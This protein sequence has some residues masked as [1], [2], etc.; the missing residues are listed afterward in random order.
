MKRFIAV[1]GTLLLI[2]GFIRAAVLVHWDLTGFGI[3]GAGAA[4]VL[5]A[6][7]W[8]WNDVLEWLRD[9]RGV[10]AVTTGISVAV[11]VAVLVML[12][13]AV[14]YRPWSVDLTASG[15]NQV[16]EQTKQLLKRVSQPVSLR[17]FGR[18]SDPR[19]EQLLRNFERE[20]SRV[21]VEIV[22][23][24]RER[25]QATRYGIIKLGTVV[26]ISGDKFRKIEDVN[27]QAIATALLQVTSNETR[28]VCFASGHGERKVDDKGPTGLSSLSATLQASNYQVDTVSLLEGDVPAK[29]NALVIAAPQDAYSQPELDR[30]TAYTD[31]QGP[32]A[33]LLEP[34]PAPSFA[35]WLKPRG[36]VP[37]GGVIVDTS[38]AGQTV[39]GGPR[40]PLA[41]RYLDHPVTRGFDIATL[42]DGARPLQVL[43]HPEYGGHPTGLAQTSARSFTTT[44]TD[45]V[46]AF[47]RAKDTAGPLTLAAAVARQVGKREDE[48]A[49]LVVFGDADFISNAFVRRQGNRDLFLRSVAWLLGEQEATVVV[50]DARENRRIDLTERMRTWMYL[51][52]LGVLPLIPLVA[53]L[54]AYFRSRR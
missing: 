37:G 33:V 2:V 14:W 24:D 26:A 15:R 34:D 3:V 54:V 17:Q 27:E 51:V 44:Q 35:D 30:L 21:H 36:I 16:S 32:V 6:I 1:P 48:Q 46:P 8:N 43:D 29:C 49:R 42:Y 25:D 18:Q 12:N 40:T 28:S 19:V 13:I 47:D 50:A 52:N 38:G 22:D 31:R 53:G 7:A 4:I 41:V 45:A 5:A 9:P 10:F 11:F 23:V 20:N 39:G